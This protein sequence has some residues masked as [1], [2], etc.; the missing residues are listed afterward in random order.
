MFKEY[1]ENASELSPLNNSQ[2]ESFDEF[3]R[4]LYD[5]FATFNNALAAVAL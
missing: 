2:N 1:V 3:K 5:S 4:G